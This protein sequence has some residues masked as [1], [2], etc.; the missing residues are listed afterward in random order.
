MSS[1]N[2]ND[3]GFTSNTS[4]LQLVTHHP[5]SVAPVVVTDDAVARFESAEPVILSSTINEQLLYSTTTTLHVLD[6][7]HTLMSAMTSLVHTTPVTIRDAILCNFPRLVNNMQTNL[8]HNL[9]SE[10]PPLPTTFSFSSLVTVGK[11]SSGRPTKTRVS[12]DIRMDTKGDHMLTFSTQTPPGI[13]HDDTFTLA[14]IDGTITLNPQSPDTTLVTLTA[15]MAV[16]MEVKNGT[17]AGPGDHS[18]RSTLQTTPSPATGD[19]I[20]SQI[21]NAVLSLH[22]QYARYEQVD[23]AM[24]KK[25]EEEEVPNAPPIQPHENDL[26][27]RS[28]LFGDDSKTSAKF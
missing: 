24:Y 10:T 16:V 28:I 12:F 8:A 3:D 22:T 1:S 23:A 25:F 6:N 17:S 15:S 4:P 5:A 26:V 9:H 14:V 27:N 11:S 18:S 7:R 2:I 19:A 20:L 13:P 21:T